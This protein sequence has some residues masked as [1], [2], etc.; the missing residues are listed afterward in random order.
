M[1]PARVLLVCLLMLAGGSSAAVAAEPASLVKART[2]Y[3]K[4][5]YDGAIAAAAE[6]RRIPEWADTAALVIAR[7]H[8]ERYRQR[9]DPADLAAGGEALVSVRAAALPPREHVDLLVGMGQYLYLSDAFGASSELFDSA[10]AQSVL[11]NG[12]ERLLVLDWWANALDRSAQSR[13][14]D[15]RAPVFERLIAR[16]QDEL[17]RDAASPVANYWLA[18]A[19]R[20]LGD[21]DRAWDAAIAGWVRSGLWPE[22]APNVR[23]DL[24]RLV[25]QVIIP[26]RVRMRGARDAAEA[27]K[28][29]RD[30][31]ELVKQQWSVTAA[32]PPLDP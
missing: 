31:W 1:A 5:D 8:L 27:T 16:M 11:L 9:S 7:A 10:L 19:A 30:E 22:T 32:P 26:E 17:R 4:A 18:A 25:T 2:L 20:G 29:M 24:D 14:A 6:A 12:Q 28:T 23:A 13:P 15:R 21:A 3:N